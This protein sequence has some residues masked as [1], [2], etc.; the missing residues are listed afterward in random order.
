MTSGRKARQQRRAPAPPPTRSTVGRRASP[1]V[2]AIGLGAIAL[3]AA[4]LAFALTGGSSS[5]S[6][7]NATALPGAD[8]VTQLFRGLPQHGTVLGPSKAPVTMVEYVDLQCPFCRSFE[9]DVL[10][11]IV[12]G[13]VRTGKLRIDARPVAILGSDSERGR[14]AALAAAAQ[15]RFYEFSQLLY[16]NQGTEN[17]GWL[18]DSLVAS[19]YASIPGLDAQAAELGRNAGSVKAKEQR[20]DAQATAFGLRQTPTVLVGKTGGH[21]AEVRSDLAS[22]TVAITRALR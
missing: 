9:L 4:A 19:A 5:P 2:L 14:A 17:T 11:D 13:Y 20:I 15:N 12:R 10:P 22:I 3:A 8:T 18:T 6:T 1:K 7:T 16:L 21:L